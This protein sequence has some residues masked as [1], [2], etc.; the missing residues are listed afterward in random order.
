MCK[1]LNQFCQ[2][3][4]SISML[5]RNVSFFLLGDFRVDGGW[6]RLRSRL[7]LS[8]TSFLGYGR[9]IPVLRFD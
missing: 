5:L 9:S 4:G 7:K 2:D 8:K 3:L 1:R 6:C